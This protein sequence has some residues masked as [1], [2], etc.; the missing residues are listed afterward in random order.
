MRRPHL[1]RGEMVNLPNGFTL[2][3]LFFGVFA[4][5]SAARGDHSRAVWCIIVAGICD[6]IDGRV[7]RATGTG[8][9]LGAQL[10]SLVD[11]ISFGLAPAL[12]M[13]FAVLNH[14]GWDWV[15]V[16]LFVACA[17]MRLARFNVEQ[18]GK[19]KKYFRGLPS[20]AAGGT[21]A[22]YYWFS[23]T[24]LY[25]QTTIADLPWHTMLRLL[26]VVL[27]LL[28]ISNVPY[29]AWPTFSL[30]TVRGVV[31]M[32]VFLGLGAALVFLPREFFFPVGITYVI[33][34]IVASVIAGLAERRRAPGRP[35][36]AEIDFDEYEDEEER[37]DD[38]DIEFDAVEPE[39]ER[40]QHS[41]RPPREARP[42]RQQPP[43]QPREP[44]QPRPPREQREPQKPR[45]PAPVESSAPG[46][47]VEDN[48]GE[49]ENADATPEAASRRRKRRRRR[50]GGESRN[51][52]RNQDRSNDSSTDRST[53]R[54]TN[55]DSTE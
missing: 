41:P 26:M 38:D 13:Y 28:M 53:D 31:G 20:P 45:Q 9:P 19:A 40:T 55:P 35:S 16:F 33:F 4:I 30:R 8:S 5:V 46:D 49:G 24:P 1:P 7:A 18:E 34:G 10:D 29:P 42:A 50:G 52:D 3:S 14:T 2:G 12:M 48:E 25:Y 17:V 27:G 6:A 32:V 36:V 43:Q 47:A 11:A 51:P 44:R 23:Q 15:L 37:E 21:L 54:D 39:S 22:T